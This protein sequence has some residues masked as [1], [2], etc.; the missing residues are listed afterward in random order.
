MFWLIVLFLIVIDQAVKFFVM[1][2]MTVGES[3]PVLPE[4]FH[5]TY[6]QNPGASFGILAGQRWIFILAGI[7]IIGA[8]VF[9]YR[10]LKQEG[11]W[12]YFG[13]S[14]LLGGAASNLIDRVWLGKVVDFFDFRI[15]PVFNTADIA[16]CVGVGCIMY[17]LLRDEWKEAHQA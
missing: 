11:P 17:A 15:W 10:R 1:G 3:I 8:G 5:I 9:F 7:L 14:L 6:I 4:I 16:I 12:I 2:S 13:S